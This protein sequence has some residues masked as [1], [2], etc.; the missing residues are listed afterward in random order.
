M[1]HDLYMTDGGKVR[2]LPTRARGRVSPAR[3]GKLQGCD[4]PLNGLLFREPRVV[5]RSRVGSLVVLPGFQEDSSVVP[6]KVLFGVDIGSP[7]I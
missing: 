6:Y 5:C 4:R 2:Q 1:R 3:I 7:G